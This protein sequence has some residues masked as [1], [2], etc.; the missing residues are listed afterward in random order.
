M[1]NFT[2]LILLPG[3]AVE[4]LSKIKG[5]KYSSVST[6]AEFEENVSSDFGHDVTPIAFDISLTLGNGYTFEKG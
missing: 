5:C 2:N 3:C 6:A 1:T 4:K